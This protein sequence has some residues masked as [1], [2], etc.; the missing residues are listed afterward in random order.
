MSQQSL[1]DKTIKGT[2]WSAID[3]SH[4]D[5]HVIIVVYKCDMY[6]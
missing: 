2:A 1:K 5:R 6:G 3:K 4:A